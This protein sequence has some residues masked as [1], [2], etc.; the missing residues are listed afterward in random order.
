VVQ[1]RI[2]DTLQRH[3]AY[4]PMQ[5]WTNG[6]ASWLSMSELAGT[7]NR[8]AMESTRRAVLKLNAAGL[9]DVLLVRRYVRATYRDYSED[10]SRMLLVARMPLEGAV[11]DAW[12]ADH[13]A[14]TER[15]R[16]DRAAFRAALSVT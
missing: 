14:R 13:D 2:L 16:R 11:Q 1:R 15:H 3:R 10:V 9:V 8:S 4:D 6:F 5:D 12:Q 7:E